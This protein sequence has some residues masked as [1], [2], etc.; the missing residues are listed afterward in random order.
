MQRAGRRAE[1][2]AARLLLIAFLA[3]A[4]RLGL[5]PVPLVATTYSG[6]AVKTNV[7]GWYLNRSHSVAV[8][9][10][11]GYYRLIVP[12][13]LLARVRGITLQPEDPPLRVG[14]GGRDGEGGDLS[15]FLQRV[16]SG[17]AG[18]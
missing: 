2:E 13:S 16:L 6:A 4:E 5:A 10:D 9:E 15:W 17:E 7:R 8:G 14:E 3:E 11:G 18:G 1:S 12:G